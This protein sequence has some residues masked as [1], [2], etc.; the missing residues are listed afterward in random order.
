MSTCPTG[1][2]SSLARVEGV[3]DAAAALLGDD[4][5]PVG[6]A[7]GADPRLERHAGAQVER[8]RVGDR[9]PV[10]HAVEESAPPFLPASLQVAPEIDPCSP[11]PELSASVVPEPASNE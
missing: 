4:G 3:D 11:F 6:R 7:R 5:A 1:L 8:G 10:V 9:D 2:D